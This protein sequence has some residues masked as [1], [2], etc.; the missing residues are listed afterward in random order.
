MLFKIVLVLMY[1][2]KP[3][4]LRFPFRINVSLKMIFV[5]LDDPDENVKVL[6]QNSSAYVVFLF[7]VW[8]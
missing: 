1:K 8:E 4:G 5:F 6:F 7:K 3:C 2:L